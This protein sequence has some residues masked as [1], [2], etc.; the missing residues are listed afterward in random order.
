[1]NEYAILKEHL[2]VLQKLQPE[3][4]QIEIENLSLMKF[5]LVEIETYF[6]VG[7]VLCTDIEMLSIKKEYEKLQVNK[8]IFYFELSSKQMFIYMVLQYPCG[9]T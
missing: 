3:Y 1:M 4:F 8:N 5:I 6:P 7:F 9:K 2:R